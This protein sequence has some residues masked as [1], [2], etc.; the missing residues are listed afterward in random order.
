MSIIAKDS[1]QAKLPPEL[2]ATSTLGLTTTLTWF[3]IERAQEANFCYFGY[4]HCMLKLAAFIC[5][6]I[7]VAIL[8]VKTALIPNVFGPYKSFGAGSGI[9]SMQSYC[10]LGGTPYRAEGGV[11]CITDWKQSF[12]KRF[13]PTSTPFCGIG[14]SYPGVILCSA[15]IQNHAVTSGCRSPKEEG[16][17]KCLEKNSDGRCSVSSSDGGWYYTGKRIASCDSNL[18]K[19]ASCTTSK[20]NDLKQILEMK[21]FES[22]NCDQTIIGIEPCFSPSSKTDCACL[23]SKYN[24]LATECGIK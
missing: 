1:A 18:P 4:T 24:Y 23:C 6:T 16:C 21:E 9:Q 3:N 22:C 15:T 20:E 14:E 5:S 19:C 10:P 12:C 11:F 13:C 7:V 8:I 17:E 2:R